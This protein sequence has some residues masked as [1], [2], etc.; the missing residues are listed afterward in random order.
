M[1]KIVCVFN[2]RNLAINGNSILTRKSELKLIE[3]CWFARCKQYFEKDFAFF[4]S[5]SLLPTDF[6]AKT[7]KGLNYKPTWFCIDIKS[8]ENFIM[9]FCYAFLYPFMADDTGF[10]SY[11]LDLIIK[12]KAVNDK[13]PKIHIVQH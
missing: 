2:T 12:Y 8:C 3:R 6:F 9:L 11:Y 5:C 1:K 4:V 10:W 13:P 7:L